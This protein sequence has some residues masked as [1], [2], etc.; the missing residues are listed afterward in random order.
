MNEYLPHPHYVQHFKVIPNTYN[1]TSVDANNNNSHIPYPYDASEVGNLVSS[2]SDYLNNTN[3]NDNHYESTYNNSSIHY[4]YINIPIDTA[5]PKQ[6]YKTNINYSYISLNSKGVYKPTISILVNNYRSIDSEPILER[7]GLN[8]VVEN[9]F[10]RTTVLDDNAPYMRFINF[11]YYSNFFLAKKDL[12]VLRLDKNEEGSTYYNNINYSFFFEVFD[13]HTPFKVKYGSKFTTLNSINKAGKYRIDVSIIDYNLRIYV[14]NNLDLT[15]ELVDDLWHESTYKYFYLLIYTYYD[16]DVT[17]I[18]GMK[19]ITADVSS[20]H[21][22]KIEKYYYIEK[23]LRSYTTYMNS[24]GNTKFVKL[25]ESVK[26]TDDFI[27]DKVFIT[28]YR[29]SKT[30]MY[31]GD[32]I[33]DL[34]ENEFKRDEFFINNMEYEVESG[35]IYNPYLGNGKRFYT[36]K[37][38]PPKRK[39]LVFDKFYVSNNIY[40]TP[41]NALIID[42]DSSTNTRTEKAKVYKPNEYRT[43]KAVYYKGNYIPSSNY[44]K[45]IMFGNFRDDDINK[46]YSSNKI[47]DIMGKLIIYTL[48]AKEVA[49]SNRFN[50]PSI[51]RQIEKNILDVFDFSIDKMNYTDTEFEAL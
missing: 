5:W 21:N 36:Y 10:Q 15:I 16:I 18:P 24:K 13:Y 8:K 48:N 40:E 22:E 32:R 39:D 12:M 51:N 44:L 43:L 35:F 1:I 4:T 7:K 49:K 28:T 17:T 33:V 34:E 50:L 46:L 37:S 42:V 25:K 23:D 2:Y 6:D 27:R 45:L 30:I 14:N 9:G 11:W 29:I 26:Q 31:R 19:D 47:E 20:T 38:N 41:G 3:I